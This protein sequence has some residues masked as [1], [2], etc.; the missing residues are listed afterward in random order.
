[1]NKEANYKCNCG[2]LIKYFENEYYIELGNEEQGYFTIDN[3]KFCYNCGNRLPK[4]K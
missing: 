4:I 1:M 2:T 3:I